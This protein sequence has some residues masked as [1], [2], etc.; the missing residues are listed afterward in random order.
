MRNLTQ[1]LLTL[2]NEEEH[3]IQ[4]AIKAITVS[5]A[6]I[7]SY[8]KDIDKIKAIISVYNEL[9]SITTIFLTSTVYYDSTCKHRWNTTPLLARLASNSNPVTKK[10]LITSRRTR[11]ADLSVHAGSITS[12][13]SRRC[14]QTWTRSRVKRRASPRKGERQM[15]KLRKSSSR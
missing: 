10:H 7:E 8:K 11:R 5:K 9:V 14:S 3:K 6:A 13:S 1:V 12:N 15:K 2:A 4:E